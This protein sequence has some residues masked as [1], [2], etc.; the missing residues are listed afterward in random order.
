MTWLISKYLL[1]AAII[2]AVSE[3]AKKTTSLAH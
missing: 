2:V 3:V 1:T